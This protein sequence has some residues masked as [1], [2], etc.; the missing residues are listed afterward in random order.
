MLFQR[1]FASVGSIGV[2]IGEEICSAVVIETQGRE[3][4]GKWFRERKIF[5]IGPVGPN[6]SNEAGPKMD[7]RHGI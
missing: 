1:T 5:A 7:G 3:L 4:L 6:I 2:G